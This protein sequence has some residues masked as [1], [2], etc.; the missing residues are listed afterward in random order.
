[1][2]QLD[3]HGAP[4]AREHAIE[5]IRAHIASAGLR[6]GDPLPSYRELTARLNVS[7]MTVKRAMEAL[8]REGVLV[9][10]DRRGAFVARQIA[11]T[12]R[13]LR[14]IGL[15][16][17]S[18]RTA[19][20]E[21]FYRREIMIGLLRQ[22]DLIKADVQFF[23]FWARNGAV[24]PKEVARVCDGLIVLGA[25]RPAVLAPFVQEHIPLV[26]ADFLCERLAVHH[27][28]CDNAALVRSA[29]ARLQALQHRELVYLTRFDTTAVPWSAPD[30]DHRERYEAF[31]ELARRQRAPWRVCVL[32]PGG[33]GELPFVPLL[34]LM[35]ARRRPTALV[36]D[37]T[38]LA[39]TAV[40]VIERQTRL[41]VPRDLSVVAVA[42]SEGENRMPGH[43]L[44][45]NLVHFREMGTFAVE[46]L[47]QR[48]RSLR[49]IRR[50][51]ERIGADFESG[52]TLAP[53]DGC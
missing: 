46:R 44:A 19:L 1:M 25:L 21:T 12:R 30:S 10:V 43:V 23:S 24:E 4:R 11:P 2:K 47:E 51:V 31:Q 8:I 29:V 14:V 35:T 32:P 17:S 6:P 22:A 40:Q 34:E 38:G 28:V 18:S 20:V 13:E 9:S 39:R 41:R 7:L 48:C 36:A 53:P 49:P 50:T 52:D 16:F 45:Q 42:G 15:L 27:V 33:G 37:S 3:G 5:Q 26:V